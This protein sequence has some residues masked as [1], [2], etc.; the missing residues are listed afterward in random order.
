MAEGLQ[1]RLQQEV[2]KFKAI[3]KEYQ[4]VINTR[5]QLDSQLTENNGVKEE[6]GLLETDSNVYKLVGPVLIKQD[7][8]EA[9]QN[10]NKRIEY[11]TGELKRLDK[12]LE[13]LDKKQ[14]SQRETLSKLQQQLQQFQVK[15]A[16]KA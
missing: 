14:D 4:K 13:D 12:T 11:I 10:V 5:Q 15:A 6:L 9:R 3:Q 1:K 8:E 16:M 7:L 2:E